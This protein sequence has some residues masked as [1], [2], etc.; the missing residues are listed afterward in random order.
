[1]QL[2][3]VDARIKINPN[4][5]LKN[6]AKINCCKCNKGARTNGQRKAVAG[7]FCIFKKNEVNLA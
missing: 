3:I 7:P 5:K 1:M 2:Q 4:K 6:F